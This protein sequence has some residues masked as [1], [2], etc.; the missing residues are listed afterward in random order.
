MAMQGEDRA[1]LN[2]N[3]PISSDIEKTSG[4]EV[5]DRFFV[6]HRKLHVNE[7]LLL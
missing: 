3:L 6:T 7:E 1:L 2:P 4:E 5:L